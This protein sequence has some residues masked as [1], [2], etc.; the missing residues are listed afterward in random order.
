MRL[1]A[2][3]LVW[4]L[5]DPTLRT[6]TSVA[7]AIVA[8]YPPIANRIGSIVMEK[9]YETL[10]TS[11][12]NRVIIENKKKIARDG[13]LVDGAAE[14]QDADS[15]TPG[16][17]VRRLLQRDSYG[18]VQWQ[19]DAYP[20]GET[21]ITQEENRVSLLTKSWEE[22][23]A[24]IIS[25]MERTYSSQRLQIN[26]KEAVSI[27]RASWPF[28][29]KPEITI[30]HFG[31]LVGSDVEGLWRDS[32]EKKA[33]PISSYMKSVNGRRREELQKIITIMELAERTLVSELPKAQALLPLLLAYFGETALFQLFQVG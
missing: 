6:T 2:A 28:L 33:E 11:I 26:K 29:Q 25:L 31:R 19:P 1:M 10:A 21:A 32:L 3:Y 13:G 22:D 30:A 16:R 12:Y 20:D 5:G 14:G 8:R 17:S 18:C 7:K 9:C 27:S 24:V 15:P 23:R 4:D